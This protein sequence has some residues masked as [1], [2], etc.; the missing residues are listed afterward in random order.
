MSIKLPVFPL[1]ITE[2]SFTQWTEEMTEKD[3]L[4]HFEDDAHDCLDHLLSAK[5][6]D[7]VNEFLKRAFESDFDPMKVEVSV[8]KKIS[9]INPN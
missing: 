4:F 7:E 5:Q 2:K 9:N 8:F 6:C 3:L 1:V